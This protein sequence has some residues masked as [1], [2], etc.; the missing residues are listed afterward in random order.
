ME[1]N[2]C[3]QSTAS[4]SGCFCYFIF[5]K[6]FVYIGETQY[7][8]VVRWGQHLSKNGSFHSALRRN[9]YPAPKENEYISL[10]AFSLNEVI[11]N[12][13]EIQRKRVT[14]FIEHKL[15]LRWVN[16]APLN[17][18]F[19]L[20]SDTTRT[21]PMYCEYGWVDECCSHIYDKATQWVCKS[22]CQWDSSKVEF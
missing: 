15:H 17:Y 11:K 16:T 19:K 4:L 3:A 6:D 10:V 22:P 18:D 13:P 21:A 7:N 12:C 14:Q 2:L 1:V 5:W 20:I 8:P 9:G